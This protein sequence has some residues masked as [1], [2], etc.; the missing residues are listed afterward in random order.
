[1]P[2]AQG[3]ES[4]SLVSVSSNNGWAR[5]GRIVPAVLRAQVPTRASNLASGDVL[6]GNRAGTSTEKSDPVT[7]VGVGDPTGPPG[8]T[9]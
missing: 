1:M 8:L 6:G 3:A 2:A 7:G 5:Q 9:W 4:D